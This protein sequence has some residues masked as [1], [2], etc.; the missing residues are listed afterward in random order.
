MVFI[1]NVSS[2][3]CI[4]MWEKFLKLNFLIKEYVIFH[5]ID[6]AHTLH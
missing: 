2:G 6:S 3:V 5:F 1:N 4:F